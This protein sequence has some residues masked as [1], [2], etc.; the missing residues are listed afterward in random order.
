MSPI[1]DVEELAH[2]LITGDVNKD[3]DEVEEAIENMYNIDYDS[4]IELISAIVPL[5]NVGQSP[6]TQK[7]YKGFAVDNT[8]LVKEEVKDE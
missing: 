2:Y 7:V 5:V 1:Q 4:F 6:L 3:A 8:W